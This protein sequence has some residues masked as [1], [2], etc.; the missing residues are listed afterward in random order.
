MAPADLRQILVTHCHADHAGSLAKLKQDTGALAYLHPLDAEMVRAGNA[1]RPSRPAP[2]LIN[3]VLYRLFIRNSPQTIEPSE[4]DVEV[5]ESDTLPFAGGFR[6]IHIPGHS[7]GQVAYLWAQH[8]GVLFAADAASN[9]LRLGLMISYE[10][11]ALG[12]QSLQKLSSF[13]FET[14]CFGHGNPILRGAAGRFRK[15]WS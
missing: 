8:G 2:D 3:R 13:D 1:F 12:L 6:A 5:N 14:V 10:E 7:A 4:I 11:L 15:K 9:I